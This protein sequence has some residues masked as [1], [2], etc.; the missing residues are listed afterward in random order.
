[1]LLPQTLYSRCGCLSQLPCQFFLVW[2]PKHLF[3]TVPAHIN[4][5]ALPSDQCAECRSLQFAACVC[6]HGSLLVFT[7]F[8]KLYCCDTRLYLLQLVMDSTDEAAAVQCTITV[9]DS[10]KEV[11]DTSV[12]TFDVQ[13]IPSGQ[14]C[15]AASS[16]LLPACHAGTKISL[17][18]VYSDS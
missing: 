12:L 15:T 6:A 11:T 8:C 4:S 7:L 14:V 3:S 16:V 13:V 2:S 5:I 9:L 1:M 18:L 17:V 10:Q